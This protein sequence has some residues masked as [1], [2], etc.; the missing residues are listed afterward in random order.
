MLSKIDYN[1]VIKIQK[2]YRILEKQVREIEKNVQNIHSEFREIDEYISDNL[3]NA[4][5]ENIYRGTSDRGISDRG[6]SDDQ[7]TRKKDLTM[8]SKLSVERPLTTH[9]ND[10]PYPY[11]D[12]NDI[13][14]KPPT[15]NFSS[16]KPPTDNFS[17]DKPPTDNFSSDNPPTD[18]FSSDKPPTDNFSSDKPPTDNFSSDKPPTDDFSSDK[19]HTNDF[20]SDKQSA[21]LSSS[22]DL[23]AD[24][25]YTKTYS[26]QLQYPIQDLAMNVA[27]YV[28]SNPDLTEITFLYCCF[29]IN[30]ENIIPFVLYSVDSKSQFPSMTANATD[31]VTKYVNDIIQGGTFVGY[32]PDTSIIYLF[33]NFPTPES[34]PGKRATINELYHLKSVDEIAVDETIISLFAQNKELI[35]ILDLETNEEIDIP[36]SGYLCGLDDK[37]AVI[38]IDENEE[39]DIPLFTEDIFGIGLEG[40]YYYLTTHRLDKVSSRYAIFPLDGINYD[41]LIEDYS[42]YNSVYYKSDKYDLW[43]IT[44]V[45]QIGKI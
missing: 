18:N 29:S 28:E 31:D 35:H 16:D 30:K 33:Y 34:L 23:S 11:D 8:M 9:V 26:A 39:D 20:S 2:R 3:Q 1:M 12:I 7:E 19:P 14:D 15:D 40:D 17:S 44:S 25:S 43:A 10:K 22:A 38:N 36:F 42:E 41:K 27:D 21:D 45:K 13:T 5:L 24:Y 32:I 37:N 6:I 4:F